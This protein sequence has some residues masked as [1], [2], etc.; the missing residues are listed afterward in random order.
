MWIIDIIGLTIEVAHE[1][2]SWR[3]YVCIGV[4]IGIIAGLYFAYPGQP[5]I[6]YVSTPAALIVMGLGFLWQIHADRT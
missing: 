2:C 3:L 1:W 4:A 6:W 5:S